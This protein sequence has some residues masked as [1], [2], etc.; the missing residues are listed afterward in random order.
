MALVEGTGVGG[1]TWNPKPLK[2]WKKKEEEGQR[3]VAE[4]RATE[5][6]AYQVKYARSKGSYFRKY[7]NLE[8]K[9]PEYSEPKSYNESLKQ[10][11]SYGFE[12]YVAPPP[13]QKLSGK[14]FGVDQPNVVKAPE[15]PK[16][17][18]DLFNEAMSNVPQVVRDWVKKNKIRIHV[19]GISLGQWGTGAEGW[20]VTTAAPVGTTPESGEKTLFP[21]VSRSSISR[22]ALKVGSFLRGGEGESGMA[23]IISAEDYKKMRTMKNKDDIRQFYQYVLLHELGH[24]LD[25]QVGKRGSSSEAWEKINQ[26]R[27]RSPKPGRGA[28]AWQE[29]PEEVV[30]V[31][32]ENPEQ[33]I[34]ASRQRSIT[35]ATAIEPYLDT[36]GLDPYASNFDTAYGQSQERGKKTQRSESFAVA[37]ANYMIPELR[38]NMDPAQRRF[39]DVLVGD[40]V[41]MKPQRTRKTRGSQADMLE[42][43][44]L[45]LR[46]VKKLVDMYGAPN[47]TR[48]SII[49]AVR[50]DE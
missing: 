33:G 1:G 7:T 31:W 29:L 39:M 21:G 9:N 8:W 42:E 11:E 14:R 45:R 3:A 41:P 30:D 32:A 25:D 24:A 16:P 46:R 34:E 15:I 12:G 17:V 2:K 19:E 35:P 28:N 38:K 18:L 6:A 43:I 5:T 49:D 26:R 20:G 40:I 50:A 27:R 23:L 48:D 44:R 47:L 37:F 36:P 4:A 22:A 10:A 13:E